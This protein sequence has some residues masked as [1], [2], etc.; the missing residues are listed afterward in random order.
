MSDLATLLRLRLAI[1]RNTLRALR[2]ESRLKI[3]FVTLFGFA[4]WVGLFG[5]FLSGFRFISFHIPEL[6]DVLVEHL[7][8][9]FFMTLL[10]ML[11]ISTGII[12]YASFFVSRETAF[13]AATPTR[14]EHIFSYKLV[15]SLMF[16]SWAMLILG[17]PLMIAYGIEA[18]QGL[19]YYVVSVTFIGLFVL[20]AAEIGGLTA[21][22]IAL[23]AP[24]LRKR[25]ALAVA[26]AAVIVAGVVGI[27]T[28]AGISA[29]HAPPDLWAKT[30]L[31]RLSFCQNPLLPSYWVARGVSSAALGRWGDVA[32]Y[33]LLT[34]SNALFGF[35]V[36]YGYATRRFERCWFAAQSP[37]RRPRILR[38]AW[39]YWLV[40]RVLCM[41][42]PSLRLLVVKDVKA[43]LRDPVQWSQALIFFGLLFVY[44]INLRNLSY[45]IESPYWQNLISF[46]NLAAT[47]LTLSTFTG[48]FV[49]PLLSLEG[50]R[51]W[52]LGLLP[53]ERRGILLGKFVSS[54]L[55]T[56][57]ISLSLILLSDGMLHVGWTMV[58]LHVALVVMICCG[59]SGIAVGLGAMYPNL[60]EESPSKIVSGYGGTLTLILSM[61]YIGLIIMLA[62][63]PC[64][65]YLAKGI[66]TRQVFVVWLGVA[67]SVAVALSIAAT[68]VPMIAGAR[69]FERME[70]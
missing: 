17:A 43:F 45:D 27:R 51:F 40:D 23:H 65:L 62:A 32:F 56:L 6:K 1:G 42:R 58:V 7:L 30:V 22:M 4:V 8:L 20:I 24:R 49:F 34:L 11:A 28:F 67:G 57:I 35:V 64:H 26:A 46:L 33:W 14:F 54:L 39:C 38:Q 60:R 52:L 48:R 55:G 70:F 12:A 21:M 69:A 10:V 2:Y 66:I 9:L 68:L 13:L 59:L 31:D 18:K 53:V 29:M 44:I 19:F 37:E 47:S 15:E 63:A 25:A 16:S 36:C 5:G 3:V 41:L 61:V 50:R